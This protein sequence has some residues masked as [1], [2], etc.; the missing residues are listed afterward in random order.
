MQK[1]ILYSLLLSAVLHSS[2][3]SWGLPWQERSMKVFSEQ[4]GQVIAEPKK[5]HDARAEKFM[6]SVQQALQNIKHHEYVEVEVPGNGKWKCRK[7]E[8]GGRPNHEVVFECQQKNPL[9]A[10]LMLFSFAYDGNTITTR[11]SLQKT[12]K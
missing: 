1:N 3:F 8:I 7:M 11:T 5:D 6:E 4:P 12:D 10:L 9:A 2:T